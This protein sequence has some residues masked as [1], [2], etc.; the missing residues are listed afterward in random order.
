MSEWIKCSERMPEDY[1]PVL[2]FFDGLTTRLVYF[3]S[4]SKCWWLA[5]NPSYIGDFSPS[6]WMPLPPPPREE[7]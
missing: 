5:D 3:D 4:T 7:T 6:H 1:L 2:A